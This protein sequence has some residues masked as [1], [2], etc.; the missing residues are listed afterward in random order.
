M[1]L[2]NI[3][4]YSFILAF[5]Y[6]AI[7][8]RKKEGQNLTYTNTNGIMKKK[9]KKEQYM[10]QIQ[11][12]NCFTEGAL[13]SSTKIGRYAIG[14]HMHQN[15]EIVFVR[16]G[17]IHV[18]V[19]S[20]CEKAQAND[21]IIIAPFSI[22]SFHTEEHANIWI[23]VFSNNFISDF[24]GKDG[25]YFRGESAV[26]TPSRDLRNFF[27]TKL[28]DSA[29]NIIFPTEHETRRIKAVLYAIFEE[30]MSTVPQTR[31]PPKSSVLSGIL[32]YMQEHYREN[33]TLTDVAK[34]LGYNPTYLSHALGELGGINFRTL[35]NSFRVEEAKNMLLS[36]KYK[37]IDIAM[38]C[39]FTCERSFYRA[40]MAI[41]GTTPGE[42]VEERIDAK[43]ITV[44]GEK[45]RYNRGVHIPIVTLD[46]QRGDGASG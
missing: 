2:F 14:D 32:T 36:K 7:I 11:I 24:I 4:A 28:I 1:S 38:E 17:E 22:H 12:S 3:K 33:I 44:G 29:E 18:T 42:Y 41:A 25:S 5:D 26:F 39:G 19:D 31:V 10:L 37:M 27:A 9:G 21:I 34:S 35:L 40:F 43:F 46:R 15:T 20:K 6:T 23:N 13:R 30:Y 45:T 8:T 16:E